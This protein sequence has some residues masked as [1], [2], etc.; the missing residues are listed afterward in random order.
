MKQILFFVMFCVQSLAQASVVGEL[1]RMPVTNPASPAFRMIGQIENFCTGTLISPRL[2]LTAAHCVYDQQKQEWMSVKTFT[3][4][5]NQ[6]AEPFGSVEVERIHVPTTYVA[7]DDRQDLAVLVLKQPIG[8]KTG[9]QKIGWDLQGFQTHTSALGGYKANGTITGYP[10]DKVDGSM[11]VAACEFYVPNMQPLLPQYRCDT[12]GGMSGSALVVAGSG[13]ESLI[14]GV[15]TKGHG[16]FN[17]GIL[18]THEN[19]A[20]LQ[21]IL[22]MYPL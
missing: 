16:R 9:W 8:L 3:P 15:H 22:A 1:S 18:L 10:G 12:F 20:F 4:A 21:Q 7:G 14:V 6:Q 2:V 13:G 5:R 17:S 19:K 11:W